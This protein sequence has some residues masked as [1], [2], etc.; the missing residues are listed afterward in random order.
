MDENFVFCKVGMIF[1]CHFNEAPPS[2]CLHSE[3]VE[4]G[5]IDQDFTWFSSAFPVPK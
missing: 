1:L 3:G 2:V 4:K 5:Q